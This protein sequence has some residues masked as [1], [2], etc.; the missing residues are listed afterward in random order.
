MELI[1]IWI[2]CYN[3]FFPQFQSG[4]YLSVE[5]TDLKLDL[6]YMPFRGMLLN[7]LLLFTFYSELLHAKTF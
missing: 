4:I 5:L 3:I 2:F 1:K 6:V 7:S